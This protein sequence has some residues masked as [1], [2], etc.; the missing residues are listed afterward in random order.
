MKKLHN[1]AAEAR[2]Y[3]EIVADDDWVVPLSEFEIL[4]GK[5]FLQF[6]DDIENN[7]DSE[8][9][10]DAEKANRACA[11]IESV[12]LLEGQNYTWNTVLLPWARLLIVTLFGIRYKR[13]PNKILR[14]RLLIEIGRGGAKSQYGAAISLYVITQDRF[15]GGKGMFIST[16]LDNAKIMYNR[17][18]E[19]CAL[20]KFLELLRDDKLSDIVYVDA[21]QT[22]AEKTTFTPR[23]P[24]VPSRI[25]EPKSKSSDGTYGQ[26]QKIAAMDE[27]HMWKE[28]TNWSRLEGSQNKSKNSIL[29][30]LTTAG[31]D[32][33]CFAYSLRDQG[34]RI[35]KGE[36]TDKSNDRWE[37]VILTLDRTDDP[38]YDFDTLHKANPFMLCHHSKLLDM[39]AEVQQCKQ[40]EHKK[41]EFLVTST[42]RWMD[43][44]FS[45]LDVEKWD[46]CSDPMYTFDYILEECE[47]VWVGLD[48][49]KD[50]DWYALVLGG[51]KG[52]KL[53][54]AQKHY[55]PKKTIL[56]LM[57]MEYVVRWFNPQKEF[58]ECGASYIQQE[59]KLLLAD[60]KQLLDTGKVKRMIMDQNKMSLSLLGDLQSQYGDVVVQSVPYRTD[61]ITLPARE[62]EALILSERIRHDGNKIMSF[63]IRNADLKVTSLGGVSIAKRLEDSEF[64]KDFV[65]ACIWVVK[66]IIETD[67][68]FFTI[69]G[70][71]SS[72]Q[73][74]VYF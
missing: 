12:P 30:G 60:L 70:R 9:I 63:Q 51:L 2:L 33:N 32:S 55:L 66:G 39:Q 54:L 61:Q 28:R 44:A 22:S 4:R 6:L 67:P 48:P 21:P 31:H 50:D 27:L 59:E 29:L 73:A 24:N 43:A 5:R 68:E 47:E 40:D 62:F 45:W 64:K 34:E 46:A 14:D 72:I 35:L 1:Y 52:D 26:V 56:R 37:V 58:I 65:D 20:P 11:W 38:F 53:M 71:E 7:P 17:C 69:E 18:K 57:T 25:M 16:K 49:S 13:D 23:D 8:Y 19:I 41:R 10:F 74:P 36:Y 42:N 15:G 3:A